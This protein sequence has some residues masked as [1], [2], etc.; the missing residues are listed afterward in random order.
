M[1]RRD[2]MIGLGFLVIFG[3][4]GAAF[5]YYFPVKVAAN[6]LLTV[7]P[8]TRAMR[9]DYI[10]MAKSQAQSADLEKKMRLAGINTV[11]ISAGRVD[12]TYFPWKSH[13]DRWS[14]EVKN[15]GLD[16]L[17]ADSTRFSQWA[18]VTAVV[19]VL[20][21]L[22][23]R[24]HPEAAAISWAGTPSKNLVGLMELV[25]GEFGQNL[26]DMINEISA[27]Y[28]VN[29]IMISEVV[30]YVDGFGEKDKAAF[31]AYSELKD[32]PRK[33]TGQ[34]DIDA[35]VI[36][37]WRVHELNRFYEKAAK[38]V[39]QNKK[40]LLVDEKVN[41][42]KDGGVSL[43]NGVNFDSVLQ[44]AD[45]L[46]VWGNYEQ[47]EVSVQGVTALA[48]YLLHDQPQ[49]TIL[50]VGLWD[51]ASSLDEPKGKMTAVSSA[52]L[53]NVLTSLKNIGVENTVISPSFLVS[54]SHWVEIN[55]LW[56]N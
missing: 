51:S 17:G 21:P 22:Y 39:H 23:I 15:S 47:G 9:V 45:R 3:L 27:N 1:S 4:G 7:L 52:V 48:K 53:K 24:A 49:K 56:G 6:P 2:W 10:D 18:H 35:P 42:S 55:K 36:G 28:P 11:A 44:Y 20:A 19:D 54:D 46:V 29:S 37:Q 38:I 5:R 26:L 43:E 12:W 16:F 14:D 13:S 32:W 25:D 34:I 40:L 50:Q 41:V 31:L 8:V 33:S 30:Y